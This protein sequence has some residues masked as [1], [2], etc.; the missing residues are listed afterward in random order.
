MSE[1]ENIEQDAELAAIEERRAARRAATAAARAAQYAID[2]KALDALEEKHGESQ[3][4]ALH[5]P[6]YVP[7]QPTMVIVKSPAGDS[8]Y[9]RFADKVREAKGHPQMMAA[10]SEVLARACIVYPADPAAVIAMHSAFPNLLND[11]ANAAASLV[12]MK[13][14]EEKKD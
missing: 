12:V 1:A 14:E 6:A 4:K 10:A 11:A 7:G 5:V 13:A 2:M 9:K 8:T 3:I